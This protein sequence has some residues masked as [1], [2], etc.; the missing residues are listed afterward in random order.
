MRVK[1][2][3][4]E[5]TRSVRSNAPKKSW[6]VPAKFER[7]QSVSWIQGNPAI[8]YCVFLDV[9]SVWMKMIGQPF[10]G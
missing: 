3:M 6:M 7:Q 10:S 4:K 8:G 1:T 9:I 5:G 2:M